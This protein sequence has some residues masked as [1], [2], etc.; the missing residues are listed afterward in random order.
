MLQMG[1][2]LYW[3]ALLTSYSDTRTNAATFFVYFFLHRSGNLDHSAFSFA[4]SSFF[5]SA[6]R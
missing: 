3:E 5:V 1:G 4:S 6:R 2:F